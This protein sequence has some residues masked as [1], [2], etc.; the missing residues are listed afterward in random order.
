MIDTHAHLYLEEFKSDLHE[1]VS[2]FQDQNVQHTY[3]P[4]IDRSTIDSMLE[5]EER[6]KESFTAMMGLHPCSVK[7]G[8]EK[9]LYLVEEWLDR[10]YFVAV[11]E[12]GIDLYWDKTTFDYQKEAFLIQTGW[13][14]ERNRP[15]VIHCRESLE[16]TIELLEPLADGRL[17]GVFHCFSGSKQQAERITNMGFMLGIGGVVTFKNSGLDTTLAEIDLKHLVLETDSPYL[18]PVPFRGKR[19]EPAYLQEIAQK[20]ADIKEIEIG[21]IKRVT[22]QNAQTLYLGNP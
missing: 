13:A 15:I 1:V 22:T 16:E 14:K 19:N 5:L 20:I 9:E 17:T 21:E 12:I 18:A 11:G 4:N 8:F 10:R 7:K 2:R 6:Y 3:L